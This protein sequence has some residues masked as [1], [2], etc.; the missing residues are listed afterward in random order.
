VAS[1]D[2]IT[3][4]ALLPEQAKRVVIESRTSRVWREGE[5]GQRNARDL[6]ISIA[7]TFEQRLSR[8]AAASAVRVR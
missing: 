5:P 8:D 3:T 4:Y 1:N 6:G 7:W 2:P